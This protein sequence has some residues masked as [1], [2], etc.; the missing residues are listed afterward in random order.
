MLGSETNSRREGG[1][2]FV[3]VGV[4]ALLDRPDAEWS[5][6]RRPRACR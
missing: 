1:L 5:P 6:I 3:G 2:V 4:P